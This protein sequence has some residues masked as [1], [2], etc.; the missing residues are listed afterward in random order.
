MFLFPG[1]LEDGCLGSNYGEMVC[2]CQDCLTV[3]RT[4]CLHNGSSKHTLS[5]ESESHHC[6][7][8]PL[9]LLL[10]PQPQFPHRLP[11]LHFLPFILPLPLAM[12]AACAAAASGPSPSTHFSFDL[13]YLRCTVAFAF[14]LG[15]VDG[16]TLA[17]GITVE[18]RVIFGLEPIG[19][20]I[21]LLTRSGSACTSSS[22]K[23]RD[24]S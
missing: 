15:R 1:A 6:Q 18:P 10:A 5:H 22:D 3:H 7:P 20:V 21:T 23:K 2:S 8:L 16:I 17:L 9:L 24:H 12:R 11:F 4:S 19:F 14:A 13:S